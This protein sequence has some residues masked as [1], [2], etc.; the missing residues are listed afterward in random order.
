MSPCKTLN[1]FIKNWDKKIDKIL[2]SYGMGDQAEDIKQDIYLY[3]CTKDEHGKNGLERYD[4]ARG[5]FSTYAYALI[6]TKARNA[7]ARRKRDLALIPFSHDGSDDAYDDNMTASRRDRREAEMMA[8]TGVDSAKRVEF[9]LQLQ[10]VM[11]ALRT[12]PVRSSFFRNGECIVRDL[13][14][15]MELLLQDKSRDEIVEYFDYSTG[16]VGVMYEKLRSVPE[17]RELYNMAATTSGME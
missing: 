17:L 11:D 15:L 3:I 12:Y 1:E 5:A 2:Q 16:S 10:Q 14:T 6:L 7:V 4:P 9:S 13:P 8:R